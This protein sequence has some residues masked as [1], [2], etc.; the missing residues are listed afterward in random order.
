MKNIS[1]YSIDELIADLSSSDYHTRWFA[2]E[3]IGTKR[4]LNAK[5]I[6]TLISIAEISDIGEVIIWGLGQ[7]RIKG[8]ENFI[9]K[10]LEHENN[11]FR[12]RAAEALRDISSEKARL[13]LEKYL[14][15]SKYE[16][17]RW[18]CAWALGEIGSIKSFSVLWRHLV[19]PDR[20]VRWKSVWAL[21][22][23]KGNVVEKIQKILVSKKIS[24][25]LI[26]RCFWILGR[27]GDM[28]TIKFL[29]MMGKTNANKYTRY[30]LDLAISAIQLKNGK[31]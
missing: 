25:F 10:F 14:D 3:I 16:E 11:Y 23:L 17:T 8:I 29:Q 21:S 20:Y 5:Q 28:K 1:K 24:N 7:M 12:W 15:K 26:W 27:R 2:A 4:N 19:D 18:K 9:G 30:Q 22:M 31:K 6:D 13:T